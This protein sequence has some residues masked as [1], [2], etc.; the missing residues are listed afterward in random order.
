MYVGVDQATVLMELITSGYN[1]RDLSLRLVNSDSEPVLLHLLH[2]W[3]WDFLWGHSISRWLIMGKFIH[4]ECFRLLVPICFH[5]ENVCLTYIFT[6]SSWAMGIPCIRRCLFLFA[7]G[8][9]TLQMLLWDFFGSNSVDDHITVQTQVF[10]P[11]LYLIQWIITILIWTFLRV[12]S[13]IFIKPEKQ[14]K[15]PIGFAILKRWISYI[16]LQDIN[17]Q[18]LT[19]IWC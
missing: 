12:C 11:R 1:S 17:I 10:N 3:Q 15:I 9:Y 5:S 8:K 18:T 14:L 19:N 6:A 16:F 2:V 4:D 7:M 13:R